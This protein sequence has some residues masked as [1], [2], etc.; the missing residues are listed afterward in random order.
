MMMRPICALVACG[1]LLGL[2]LPALPDFATAAAARSQEPPST[3]ALYLELIRQA[4]I[5]G[6]PRAALAF[7]DDFDRSYSGDIEAMVLRINCL[8]DLDAVPEAALLAQRLPTGARAAALGADAVR[9]HVS[10]AQQD[11]V[12]AVRHYEGAIRAKPTDAFLLSALG[13]ARIHAG[14]A[15]EA[16]EDLRA[17]SE[18]APRSP[19]IRNNLMLAL[20]LSGDGS[21]VKAML[22][23]IPEGSERRAV[24]ATLQAEARA[25]IEQLSERQAAPA[26]QSEQGDQA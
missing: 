9:G 14:G 25:I 15:R 26:A 19:V 1:V 3:R 16:V 12:K 17:A 23:A 24:D 8:L 20:L 7:L 22:D 13:Y 21:T 6:K 10:A 5:D 4:R 11:W 2:P 18:L